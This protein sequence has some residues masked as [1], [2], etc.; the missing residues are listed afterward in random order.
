MDDVARGDH[1]GA[2]LA[3]GATVEAVEEPFSTPQQ[4]RHDRHVELVDEAGAQVLLDGAGA[5]WWVRTKT[6]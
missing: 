1:L 4:D 2:L 5:W 3:L 6:G